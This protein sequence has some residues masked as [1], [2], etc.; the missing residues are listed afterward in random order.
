[1]KRTL[2]IAF[3]AIAPFLC[4]A[5]DVA[6]KSPKLEHHIGVQVNDLIKQT[7]NLA[8][9]TAANNNPYL[10]TYN[11]NNSKG[12]GLRVGAGYTLR[13]IA[14]DNGV[15]SVKSDIDDLNMRLGVEKKFNLGGRWSTGVGL[16]G[17]YNNDKNNTET[18]VR[19]FDTTTTKTRS[20]TT[21][22]GGGAMAWL[23]FNITNR[24]VIGTEASF[25]YLSGNKEQS[26]TITTRNEALPGRPIVTTISKVDD[27]TK[28]AT[29]NLPVALYLLI[30]F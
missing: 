23:R 13:G 19:A 6:T 14:N 15:N 26:V 12:W 27:G 3:I 28:E 1:M 24:V 18:V 17:L 7:F 22:Y 30:R 25:Y 21:S 9:N 8:N 2:S 29:F 16:D 10:I 4:H 20:L 11:I 5:Q